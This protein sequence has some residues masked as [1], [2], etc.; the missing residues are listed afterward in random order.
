MVISPKQFWSW[1]SFSNSLANFRRYSP[2][3]K[4]TYKLKAILKSS[5]STLQIKEH[6]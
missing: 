2:R 5:E 3:W 6:F 1:L 4:D